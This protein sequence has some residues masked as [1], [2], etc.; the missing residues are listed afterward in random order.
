MRQK[1]AKRHAADNVLSLPHCKK[2][3]LRIKPDLHYPN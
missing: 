1:K 3:M 2:L